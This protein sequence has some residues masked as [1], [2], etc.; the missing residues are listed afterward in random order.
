[1]V[2]N[3]GL[4]GG[5]GM[6]TLIG[7]RGNEWSHELGH[8]FGRGHHPKDSSIHD[9]ESGWGWDARYQRFIGNLHWS[10]AAYTVENEHSGE[11]V[12]PFANEFRFMR[13][14]MAGG[15]NAR[16]GLISN[17]T[18]EHPIAARVT[19]D[20]FNRS[21]NLD[22]DT[23]TGFSQWDQYSQQYVEVLSLIHI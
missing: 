4:S 1:M 13:E 19:Q 8:N 5:G 16:T 21:N 10:G 3:H 9:M 11:V 22:M 15:E 2:V 18:L 17:Y 23:S 7:S 6:V 20:W 14:A 12:P